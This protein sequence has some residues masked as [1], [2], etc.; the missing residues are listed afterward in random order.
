MATFA[1]LRRFGLAL[2]GVTEHLHMRDQPS[3]RARGKMFALWWEPEKTTIMKLERH[4]QDMLFEMRPKVFIPCKVGTGMW[5]YVDISK[6]TSAELKALVTEA[7]SQVVPEKLRDAAISTS[8]AAPRPA[9]RSRPAAAKTTAAS[10]PSP[11]Q[12]RRR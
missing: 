9:R 12:R 1:E 11:S 3:L 4:H 8:A 7:W 2:P 10:A 6:L 5:S